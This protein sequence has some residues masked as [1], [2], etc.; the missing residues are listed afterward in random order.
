[1]NQD[2]MIERHLRDNKE[3]ITSWEAFMEYGITRLSSIIHRLRHNRCLNITAEWK[4][5]TNRY[6]DQTKFKQ[7]KLVKTN[8]FDFMKG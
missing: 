8:L 4:Y 7:Y 2:E 1:M 6:G 3:G 5:R